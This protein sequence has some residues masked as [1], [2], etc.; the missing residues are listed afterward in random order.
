MFQSLGRLFVFCFKYVSSCFQLFAT[1]GCSAHH[2][3]DYQQHNN[4]NQSSRSLTT[5]NSQQQQQQQ[6]PNTV[7]THNLGTNNSVINSN[8]KV[9]H[10]NKNGHL[11]NG[12]LTNG[13]QQYYTATSSINKRSKSFQNAHTA[14]INNNNNNYHKSVVRPINQ[15]QFNEPI[16]P[17]IPFHMLVSNYICHGTLMLFGYMNDFLRKIGWIESFERVEKNREGYTQLYNTFN[18]FYIRNIILR[19]INMWS[20]PICSAPGGYTEILEREFGPYNATWKYTGRKIKAINMG[21]YDYLGHSENKGPRIDSVIE[22]INNVGVSVSSTP[23]EFGTTQIYRELETKVA[24]YLGV[25]DSVVIG[26]GFATNSLSLP[27]L[28]GPGSLVI[29]DECNHASLALGCKISGAKVCVFKHNN[30]NHLEKIITESLLKG[31]PNG[32]QWRKIVILIEGIYSMEGTIV[33]LPEIIRIKKK[34]RAY[35]YM[36]E[37]HSIGAMGS[38]GRGICDYYGCDPRDIDILMGT[39]TKSFAAAGGYIAGDKRI[40]NYIRTNSAS[41]FYGTTMAPPICQQISSILDDFLS[42]N[43]DSN[44]KSPIQCRIFQLRK[45]VFRFRQKLKQLGFH[46]DGNNDSPVVPLMV[47]TPSHLKCLISKLLEKGVASTGAAFPVTSLTGPRARFCL[48]ASHT[49]QMIDYALKCLDEIGTEIG[50]KF[51][52]NKN[53]K[54]SPSHKCSIKCQHQ[55]EYFNGNGIAVF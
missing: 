28:F 16:R 47:Y 24:K 23:N 9:I 27:C 43:T 41:F 10:R 32:E 36:D 38:R 42:L 33:N 52:G 3:Q 53:L 1:F 39:F 40:I 11:M 54:P 55:P 49:D 44:I 6:N 34:Y 46:I 12:S 37:A 48:S 4:N 35:V 5:N 22:T 17:T 7:N 51:D 19:L 26:M 29:S 30:M 31:Q 45:N 15:K 14:I 8:G 20:H 2:H 18:P 21:S 13:Y 25:E 50:I